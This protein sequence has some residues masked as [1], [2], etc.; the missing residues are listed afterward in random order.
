M[1]R[2][3]EE[4]FREQLLRQGFSR[5]YVWQDGAGT[6]YP[7]H[8]HEGVTA[9]IILDGEMTLSMRGGSKTYHTGDRCDVPAG[10]VHAARMGPE[11]C[12]YMI[13]ER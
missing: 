4:E 13:G 7:D 12:R 11:G 9:H 6:F 5:V 10:A 2:L 1:A 8:T 3:N